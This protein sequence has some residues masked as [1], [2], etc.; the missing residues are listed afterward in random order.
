MK[1]LIL[2][3]QTKGLSI[4][5]KTYF[6]FEFRNKDSYIMGKDAKKYVLH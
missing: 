1:E 2:Y 3:G 4:L 6:V 5:E